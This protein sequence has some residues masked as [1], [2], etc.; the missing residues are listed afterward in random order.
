MSSTAYGHLD[1]V[2]GGE[3]TGPGA[4]NMEALKEAILKMVPNQPREV[5]GPFLMAV[6]HC[7]AI[8]GQGTVLTGTVLQVSGLNP[9]STY[10]SSLRYCA[11]AIV[12][13][14]AGLHQGERHSGGTRAALA[15]ENQEHADV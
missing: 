7:F 8:K 3:G 9:R 4:E 10:F 13:Q 1:D 2:G 11:S 15:E 12:S 5:H 14:P 6:D